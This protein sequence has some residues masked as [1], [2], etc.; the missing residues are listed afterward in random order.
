[1]TFN[2]LTTTITYKDDNIQYNLLYNYLMKRNKKIQNMT[3][4]FLTTTITYKDDNIE[5]NL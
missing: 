3:F 1:M 2:F 5:Y 4:N